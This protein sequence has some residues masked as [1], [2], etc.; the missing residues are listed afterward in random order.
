M[1]GLVLLRGASTSTFVDR[2][3]VTTLD[4]VKTKEERSM[5]RVMDRAGKVIDQSQDPNLPRGTF[6]VS[7]SFCLPFFFFSK[8]ETV[9][10]MYT[11]MNTLNVMDHVLYEVQR[12]VKHT[13]HF[14]CRFVRF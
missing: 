7:C 9:V 1:K 12:Q 13:T 8:K 10:K 6:L 5:Y 14:Y 2:P 4:L 3:F 11:V